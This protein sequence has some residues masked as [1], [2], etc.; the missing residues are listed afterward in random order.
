[1]ESMEGKVAVVTGAS[2]GIGEAIAR[3]FAAAGAK[4]AV[5]ARTVEEGAHQLP[6]SISATV[7]A[8]VDAGGSAVAV[9]ADLSK[10]DDRARM[11][12]TVEREL[13]PIDVLVN[14]AAVT[15][16]EPLEDFTESRFRLMFDLQVRAPF[17]LVQRV[18]PGMRER[19]GGAILNVSS[20]AALHPPGP[21]F[22]PKYGQ[23]TVYG[24]CKAA[25]E[26]FTTGLAAELY[27][28]RIAVNCVAPA[29]VVL[30]P[31]VIG[32]GL[33]SRVPADRHEPIEYMVEAAYALCTGDPEKLTGRVAYAPDLLE[34]LG[35]KVSPA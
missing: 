27:P 20:R 4:V 3:R 28:H 12:E 14:N 30:T 10:A 2:R 24:M 21:P 18:V 25:V 1:M 9:A 7:Q 5:T 19:G 15:F 32:H 16:Y 26:R 8:I 31:G 6:G 13:G 29:G 33:A 11:V 35:I 22:D 17:D 34:E 23:S